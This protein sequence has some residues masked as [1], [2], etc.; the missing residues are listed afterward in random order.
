MAWDLKVGGVS[1]RTSIESLKPASI[2][3]LPNDRSKAQFCTVFGYS[4]ARLSEVV[5]YDQDGTTPLFGGLINK[6]TLVAT[7]ARGA[8][9]FFTQIDCVDFLTYFDLKVVS[10][11]YDTDTDVKTVLT[12]LVALLPGSYG[13]TVDPAQ[14]A[15][16][17]VSARSWTNVK[18]STILR[19]VSKATGYVVTV[20]P[21]KVTSMFAPRT[22]SA[23]V[24]M[25]DAAPNCL[26]FLWSDSDTLPPN[27]VV[28]LIGT[29]G[30]VVT[31]TW[32]W[33]T[34]DPLS[35]V[36]D[37]P[38]DG[39]GWTRGAV[40]INDGV[41]GQ[42]DDTISGPG[43]GGYFEYDTSTHTLT[44][45]SGP[46]LAD[47][48]TVS[49]EYKPAFPYAIER[50]TGATPEI[51]Y[52]AADPSITTLAAGQQTADGILAQ[53]GSAGR[54]ATITSLTTGFRPGQSLTV[55]LTHRDVNAT[56]SVT[57]VSLTLKS[58]AYWVASL[59]AQES[60]TY[61][62]NH[63]D[64]WAQI[65]GSGGG[66][67]APAG[68]VSSISG[69]GGGSSTT[70]Q[71]WESL[72]GSRDDSIAMTGPVAAREIVNYGSLAPDVTF[73][74]R[75]KAQVRSRTAGVGSKLQLI[76]QSDSVV[77]AE[78]AVVSSTSWT[79]VSITALVEAGETYIPYGV[80][81]TDYEDPYVADV[82]WKAAA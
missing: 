73:T 39:S 45:V 19:D 81:D 50:S 38:D 47:G 6:R 60:A 31:Q 74:A 55:N 11:S 26:E 61:E 7:K 75:I 35:F 21:L 27:N 12:D 33:H 9:P 25:V 30:T 76:R 18:A 41:T 23:P 8:A 53:L 68:S 48:D 28:L 36:T 71:P 57:Q 24:T 4:P 65:I 1:K 58:D 69:G 43:D 29:A 78:S 13:M 70:I 46:G 14:V 59:T 72:G 49:F 42:R 5:V 62:G 37:F 40:R 80:T 67:A 3:L 52:P 64:Q 2:T 34:G 16:P 51:D 10:L 77:V 17:A 66:S 63:N 56:F 54:I 32:T 20:S 15:G 79:D 44:Q 22:T 82:K